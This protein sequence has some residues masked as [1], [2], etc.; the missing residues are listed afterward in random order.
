[1]IQPTSAESPLKHRI[2]RGALLLGLL[3]QLFVCVEKARADEHP[4]DSVDPFIGTAAS[5]LLS[6]RLWEQDH[7]GYTTPAAVVPWGM[8]AVGPDTTF[9][10]TRHSNASGYR[11]EDLYLL[12]FSQLHISG[13]GCPAL[14]NVR[15]TP[16]VGSLHR[17]LFGFRS[18]FEAEEA[19][20]G[21]YQT[22]LSRIGVTASMSAS[23]RA[24]IMRFSFPERRDDA[25]ILFDP[26]SILWSSENAHI[27]VVSPTEIEGFSSG[28]KFCGTPTP[29]RAHFVIRLSKPALGSGT[30]N[31]N[32][33]A[34]VSEQDGANIGAYLQFSTKESE[35]IL[36]RTGISYVSIENARA[37]LDA[38][39]PDTKSF[40]SVRLEARQAW[41]NVLGRVQ[42]TGGSESQRKI[43]YTALYHMLIHPSTFSDVNGEFREYRTSAVRVAK[44]YV[45]YHLFSLWDT[46]RGLHSF[47]ALVYP[48]R[49]ID[50]LKT[51][52]EMQKESG[53]FPQW[54][55]AGIE[56]FAM[57]GDPVIGLLA[58]G[59]VKG[60][61]GI[62][63][64]AVYQELLKSSG[65][66][67]KNVDRPLYKEFIAASYIP[68]ESDSNAVSTTLE[69]AHNDWNI[70]RL[71]QAF[72]TNDEHQ[73]FLKRA[74]YWRSLLRPETGWMEPR[75]ADG[76]WSR[77]WWWLP[78]WGYHE[79]I[80]EQYSFLVLHDVKGMI[81]VLG[82]EEKF[83]SKVDR[84]F[85]SYT[86]TNQHDFHY[87]YLYDFAKG[88]ASRTQR[89]V[90]KDLRL[91][92]STDAGGL[93][94][95][96][97]AGSTSAVAVYDSLGF[98]P[99][100]PASNCY[101][102]GSPVF[103]RVEIKLNS[104]LYPGKGS[105]VIRTENNSP[106]NLYIQSATLN[107]KDY[108]YVY[109]EHKDIVSG[110]ELEFRMDAKPSL[111]G[112]PAEADCAALATPERRSSRK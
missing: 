28:G 38:E 54:E 95:N 105:F 27:R 29:Y 2:R 92:F 106:E 23:T 77:R 9:P 7:T 61:P 53:H 69:Y 32:G 52:V 91:N 78:L 85:S 24:S 8:V 99:V 14:G 71:A 10:S 21:F 82:G 84:A 48:E 11:H 90:R 17:R 58:D 5:K 81:E 103:D 51:I 79:G 39:I 44:D 96:D 13:A 94:G 97:D 87:P 15:V 107:G 93:P 6:F 60:L 86:L 68:Y 104:E 112:V 20:P 100:N 4:V 56:T 111:W 67:Q 66:D 101:A 41:D 62:D 108:P 12:G 73:T 89:Q 30:W 74:G 1:M 16:W 57:D 75:N 34:Q 50:M 109:L 40:E 42:V 65:A 18:R 35:E 19:S 80:R 49:A 26:S 46:Y 98:Y 88:Y 83:V 59:F 3:L 64:K 63:Y 47:L 70:A 31:A 37:N 36:L 22:Y 45:R 33:W 110:G 76:R 25:Y 102:I 55:L 43:F 72:G